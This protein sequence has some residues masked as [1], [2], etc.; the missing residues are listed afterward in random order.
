MKAAKNY[1]LLHN[2]DLQLVI[3]GIYKEYFNI[4]G[5]MPNVCE[6]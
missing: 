2:A 3:R 1:G 4:P 5:I 6:L